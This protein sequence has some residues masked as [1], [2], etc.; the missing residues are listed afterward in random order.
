V[1][2][3]GVATGA[4]VVAAVLVVAS[5]A[6]ASYL[7]SATA[8]AAFTTTSLAAPTGVGAAGG[9]AGTLQPKVTLTWTAT[10]TTFATGYDVYRAVGLGASTYLTTVTP[11][12]A[13]SYVDTAVS[14][15]TSYTYTLKTKYQSWTK[16]SSTAAAIT[17]AVCL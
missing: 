15:L 17:P 5:P 14:L 1:R 11:R 9:C 13:T 16:A 6:L 10:T 7:D 3:L 2:R 8:T 12:T 4:G